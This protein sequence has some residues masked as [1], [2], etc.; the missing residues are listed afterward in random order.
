VVEAAVRHFGALAAGLV[1]ADLLA[2]HFDSG[3]DLSYYFTLGLGPRFPRSGLDSRLRFCFVKLAG[4]FGIGQTLANLANYRSANRS[5]SFILRVV[6]PA[7]LFVDVAEQ[8][9][10]FNADIG[11]VQRPLQQTPEVLHP[12]S[13]DIAVG[14]LNSMVDDLRAGSQIQARHRTAVHH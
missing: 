4:E 14:V 7:S 2:G 13:V 9:E 11:S 6:E 12:V 1:V 8:M 10:R 5:A 3:F